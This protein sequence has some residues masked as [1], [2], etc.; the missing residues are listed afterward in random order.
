MADSQTEGMELKVDSTQLQDQY[1]DQMDIPE[2][3]QLV[4][5]TVIHVASDNVFIDIGYKSEGRIPTSEFEDIPSIGDKV[6]VWLEKKEGRG[7]QVI[8][9]KKRAD[10]KRFWDSIADA[11]EDDTPITGSFKKVVKGGYEVEVA[12]EVFA[13]CPLSK[14]DIHRIAEPET[15][16]GTKGTFLIKKIQREGKRTNLVVSRRDYL[17]KIRDEGMAKFFES[18]NEGDVI[19]GVV[20]SF[21]SFGAFIDL[22]GF[23]A[24]LHV[25]DMSWGHAVG[26]K[27]F[28]QRGQK[29]ELK[30]IKV[31]AESKKINLSLKH[32]GKDPWENFGTQYAVDQIVNGT[33]TKLASFGAFVE[34]EPGIEG[35]VHISELS[36]V[37]RINH[38]KEVL[39][40]GQQVEVKILDFDLEERRLSLGIK[41]VTDNPWNTLECKYPPGSA[42]VRK[43]VGITNAGLFFE[44]EDGIDAYLSAA[45]LSWQKRIKPSA[46][47]KI[48]D[49][50]EVVVLSIDKDA[51]RIRVGKKQLEPNPWDV[52]RST[53]PPGTPV[54]GEVTNITNFGIFV[55]IPG[56]IE[57]LIPMAHLRSAGEEHVDN[58]EE[59][60][61]LGQTV[62]AAVLDIDVARER[63]SL[64]IKNLQEHAHRA[65]I[66]QY[67][68]TE[69]DDHGGVSLGE[70][71]GT[72][73]EGSD[74]E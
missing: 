30:I 34:L 14:A 71:L 56:G 10:I 4:E 53:C 73:L 20:K 60:F 24:L 36:W 57:G 22:G 44:I 18:K 61:S 41:Q 70:L 27:N 49:E 45:D 26:P 46:F 52:L 40:E 69:S 51:R 13:F 31:D 32:M 72:Q 55:R 3:N 58:P 68:H 67:L 33:V 28:V 37:K 63:L 12:P 42:V 21:T 11:K 43:V 2:E 23:D 16:I 17:E 15:L 38:P 35:L 48:G 19:E 62:Q 9:S 7:G 25:N 29:L 59:K 54:E 39:S 50:M 65:Q 64:S 74:E 8:V 6:E 5:G 47:A 66:S 1:L